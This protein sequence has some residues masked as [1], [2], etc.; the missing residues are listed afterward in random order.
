MTAVFAILLSVTLAPPFG[1]AEATAFDDAGGLAIEVSVVYEGPAVTV[2]ARPIS[3]AGE[4][5][6]VALVQS[7]EGTWVGIVTI[8]GDEEIQLAF[9][10]IPSSGPVDISEAVTLTDLGVDPALFDRSQPIATTT[11]IALTPPN[12]VGWGIVAVIAALAAL[13]L[14]AIWARPRRRTSEA[15]TVE[16]EDE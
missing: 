16:P 15:P 13:V 3:V 8:Q 14:I 11:T 6:P 9:E 7:D 2:L 10:A 12:R 1:Q 4:L 5:P